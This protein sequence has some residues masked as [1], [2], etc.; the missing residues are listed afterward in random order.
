MWAYLSQ[1]DEPLKELAQFDIGVD[2]VRVNSYPRAGRVAHTVLQD[3]PPRPT[4]ALGTVQVRSAY[5][6]GRTGHTE[7]SIHSG[8]IVAGRIEEV[9]MGENALQGLR[10]LEAGKRDLDEHPGGRVASRA[11]LSRPRRA[12]KQE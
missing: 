4:S 2:N 1:R 8:H 6:T 5:H 7:H 3:S 11:R 9:T 12:A 10:L